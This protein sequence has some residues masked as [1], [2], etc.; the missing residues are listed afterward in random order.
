M[1]TWE[2]MIPA[3]FEFQTVLFCPSVMHQSKKTGIV[4]INQGAREKTHT[5]FF[6][7]HKWREK[8]SWHFSATL[9]LLSPALL[10]LIAPPVISS[11]WLWQ[12]CP[13]IPFSFSNVPFHSPGAASL[14]LMLLDNH[15]P[16]GLPVFQ[17]SLCFHLVQ[18]Q[19]LL[20]SFRCQSAKIR[21]PHLTLTLFPFRSTWLK[22]LTFLWFWTVTCFWEG[23]MA[24]TYQLPL[25]RR[26]EARG[27]H[28]SSALGFAPRLVSWLPNPGIMTLTATMWEIFT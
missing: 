1:W 17:A 12:Y 23:H 15:V 10:L 18:S 13:D 27:C 2:R 4:V 28:F 5:L 6:S 14:P 9:P 25:L 3:H 20:E 24:Q 21:G 11:H 7:S 22:L 26:L 16:Q 8:S 19:M